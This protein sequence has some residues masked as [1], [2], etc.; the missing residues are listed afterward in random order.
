[1]DRSVYSI[2]FH[3]YAD[4]LPPILLDFK[5]TCRVIDDLIGGAKRTYVKVIRCGGCLTFPSATNF[6][7]QRMRTGILFKEYTKPRIE[8]DRIWVRLEFP[9][10]TCK[11]NFA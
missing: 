9:N 1:M 2:C 10:L 4:Q 7:E 11:N 3:F 5:H 8:P 6:N